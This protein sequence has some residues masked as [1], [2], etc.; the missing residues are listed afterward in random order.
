MRCISSSIASDP[1]RSR[2]DICYIYSTFP[3]VEREDDPRWTGDQL[4]VIR[5]IGP[6]QLIVHGHQTLAGCDQSNISDVM[7]SGGLPGHQTAVLS[8]VV[9]CVARPHCPVITHGVFGDPDREPTGKVERL[10]DS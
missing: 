1:A 4:P 3:I 7:V 8:S 6:E 2:D 9:D 5:R 10:P